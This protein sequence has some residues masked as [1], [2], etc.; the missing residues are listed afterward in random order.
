MTTED[1]A[2]PAA[3][4]QTSTVDQLAGPFPPLSSRRILS[5]M[6]VAP[7]S[8]NSASS[9]KT[10]QGRTTSTGAFGEATTT[11]TPTLD[12]AVATITRA[13]PPGA[14][15]V[16]IMAARTL[17][18]PG[19]VATGA[20]ARMPIPPGRASR[21]IRSNSPDP[22]HPFSLAPAGVADREA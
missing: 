5:R 16:A 8:N 3:T 4:A 19:P 6:A 7:P 9:V 15:G 21:R 10:P 20:K 1:A 12:P 14:R 18:F 13:P 11:T 22:R 2:G 17:Q